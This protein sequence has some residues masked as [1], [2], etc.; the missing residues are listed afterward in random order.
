MA[1]QLN[2]G[3]EAEATAGAEWLK[4]SIVVIKKENKIFIENSFRSVGMSEFDARPVPNAKM[5]FFN[6]DKIADEFC[7]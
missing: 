2:P 3:V 6:S 5:K 7:Y 4:A 1:L